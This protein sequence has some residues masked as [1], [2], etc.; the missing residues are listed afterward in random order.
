M[1]TLAIGLGSNLGHRQAHLDQA[2]VQLAAH[3]DIQITAVSPWIET[4]PVGFTAETRF[5]NG[6]ALLNTTLSPQDLLAFFKTLE[7][8]AGRSPKQPGA[9][10]TSRPLDLD[11]L[12]YDDFSLTT[13]DLILPHPHLA[14]RLFVLAPL[15]TLAPHWQHPS[16]HKTVLQLL[17]IT[18][19]DTTF[20][21]DALPHLAAKLAQ[22]LVPGDVVLLHGDMGAG[23]TTFT[24]A[25]AQALGSSDWVSSPT[26]TLAHTY[27]GPKPMHHLDLYRLNSSA[28]IEALDL[29]LY[30]DQHHITCIEWP[31]RLGHL[32]PENALHI[33]LI[34]INE[35]TRQLRLHIQG[36]R[37]THFFTLFLAPL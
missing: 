14:E 28:A 36:S 30:L 33:E 9:P 20:T 25:L 11:L 29:D 5:L 34:W 18:S 17:E 24:A 10:Y 2:L 21:L 8:E 4:D 35:T 16:L 12:F 19:H 6:A 22:A 27:T 3:P 1:A 13:P 37:H 7:T 15:A 31:E 32:T 26:F 23:K